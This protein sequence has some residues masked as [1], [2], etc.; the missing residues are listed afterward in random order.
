M[1]QCLLCDQNLDSGEKTV[2]PQRRGRDTINNASAQRGD[3]LCIAEGQAVHEHCRRVYTNKN[4]ISSFLK[5]KRLESEAKSDQELRSKS[6]SF[7]FR[8]CCLFCG[9]E[10]QTDGNSVW[11]VRTL[12]FQKSIMTNCLERRDEWAEKVKGRLEFVS[13]LPAADAVY[14][15]SCSTNFRTK[16]QVPAS[17]ATGKEAKKVKCGRP[18]DEERQ[19]AF[20]KVATFLQ[21]NDTE[22]I[23]INDLMNMMNELTGGNTYCF[24]KMKEELIKHFGEEL[25]IAELDGKPNVATFRKTASS[26]LHAFYS[27]PHTDDEEAQKTSII[28]AAA[29][30]IKS[31]IRKISVSRK[32]YPSPDDVAS[33][34]TNLE[35]VPKSLQLLLG[36]IYSGKDCDLQIAS[37]GQ[38]IMQAARPRLLIAPLQIGLGVQVHH[39]F[40]SQF[41]VD[42]LYSLG[43]CSS[44]KEVR[45][46]ELSAATVQKMNFPA[47]DHHFIQYMA[48]NVDH[49]VA[50]L[51]GMNTF[52]GMGMIAAITPTV[53]ERTPIPRKIDVKLEDVIKKARIDIRYYKGEKHGMLNLRFEK[54]ETVITYDPTKE[55]EILWKT[56]WLLLPQRPSWSGVMQTVHTGDFPGQASFIFMP[57]IDLHPSDKTCI[58][59]TLLFICGEAKRYSKTPIVTF[60]QPLWWKALAI[61]TSEPDTSDLHGI[62]LRLGPFHM[63]MSFL[64]CIGHLM[65]D[66]GLQEALSV[67]YAPNAVNA[68]LQGKAVTRA[69]R[70]HFLVDAALNALLA[71]EAFHAPLPRLEV[72]MEEDRSFDE[73]NATPATTLSDESSI[74]D[75]SV[76]DIQAMASESHEK[77]DFETEA[78]LKMN[79]ISMKD[80]PHDVRT[81]IKSSP[82]DEVH[83]SVDNTD[84]DFLEAFEIYRKVI[85]G[86]LS[87]SDLKTCESICKITKK[88]EDHTMAF[89][90]RTST[91]WLQYMAMIDILKT[92]IKAERTGDWL[93]HLSAVDRMLPFLAAA[94]HNLYTKSAR[95]YL[96]MM[97]KLP[98]T[99]PDVY[100][101]FLNGH[102]V[103][104]RSQRFWAGLSSDLAIEQVLMRS[105]KSAGG[106]TR[107]RGMAESQRATWILSMPAC[108]EINN[109]M[110]ELTSARRLSSE[111]HKELG[112]TRTAK[113]TKDMMALTSFLEQ[114]SPFVDDP[115]LRNIVTGVIADPSVNVDNAK[116][117]GLRILKT[118]DGETASN[119]VLRKKDKAVTMNIKYAIKIDDNAMPVDPQLLFQRLV[120]AANNMYDDKTDVFRHE[121]CS[122]PS[123]L[124]ESPGFFLQPN[125]A[126]LAD[127]LWKKVKTT[128]TL[129]QNP[130]FVLDGGSLL[131]RIPWRRGTTFEE[132]V[133]TYVFFVRTKYQ[134]AVIVFDGYM[135]GPTTKDIIH[136]KRG[137]GMK[138]QTV[139]FALNM[140]LQSSK[141]QFL[142]NTENKQRFIHALGSAL[143]S[144]CTVIHA[145]SDADFTIVQTA[146]KCA[147]HQVTAVIGEDT[148]I[149]VLLVHHANTS[150]HDIFFYS[151]KQG[152]KTRCWNIKHLICELG[153]SRHLLLS[154]HALTGCDTT[155][156]PFGVGKGRAFQKLEKNDELKCLA[157]T[158]LQ[159]R[160]QDDIAEV[161]E[162]DLV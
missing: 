24:T 139:H 74:Q 92:F 97:N 33:L 95:L 38:A 160:T 106:L 6:H 144:C 68:M 2:V 133:Q 17:F 53:Q 32:S 73:F 128:E 121:L 78:A 93:L 30:L 151:D 108:A 48:D 21:D 79:Q 50:T 101:S 150:D 47:D 87:L 31:D 16:R 58:Y 141:E 10:A 72:R 46:Y 64:A 132:I 40:E 36:T 51:D 26:I 45:T 142:C 130:Q 135:S 123:A 115:S 49:N 85:E 147:Q 77:P 124:F 81:T 155:S 14:H 71:S 18:K 103:I 161:G 129:P 35:F 67:V 109:S 143:E 28:K 5:K 107:G 23:T 104:R 13:D 80:V 157:R 11:P 112:P 88:L 98:E 153:E 66:T 100:S 152:G 75:D 59:S 52:H 125:K 83:P 117:V 43:F 7:D 126:A 70:G 22:Q 122:F 105:L 110:Q 1:E 76:T 84:S 127:E 140:A 34:S 20:R 134:N 111:Q 90:S 55:I 154:L 137:K 19:D 145:K 149:L 86:N 41:L 54:L 96:Q 8:T 56:S 37:I 136:L 116:E 65:A 29:E 158:F 118:M 27:D 131:Q 25:I 9:R 4:N 114:H 94:G 39:S 57:M 60:D 82:A 156:R 91:L 162:K 44:Y 61:I 15:Q 102:H 138:A 63:E 159:Q 69:V 99:H 120:A 89:N 42:L 12:D 62:V 148:D 113:D 146:T 3:T 119:V